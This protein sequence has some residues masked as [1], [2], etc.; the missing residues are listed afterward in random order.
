MYDRVFYSF[1]MVIVPTQSVTAIN[2]TISLISET[3]FA[4][5]KDKPWNAK[6]QISI[7]NL[8]AKLALGVPGCDSFANNLMA[9]TQNM[10]AIKIREITV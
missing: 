5:L 6:H 9:V 4:R 3:F 1:K 7:G 2:L 10:G 8:P